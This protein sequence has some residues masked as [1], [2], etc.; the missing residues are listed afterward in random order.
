MITKLAVVGE[1]GRVVCDDSLCKK[2]GARLQ[3]R[4]KAKGK[5]EEK[6]VTIGKFVME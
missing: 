5:F 3:L 6:I 1:G 2:P 4:K